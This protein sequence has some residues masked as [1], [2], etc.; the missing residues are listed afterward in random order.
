MRVAHFFCGEKM[1]RIEIE[2]LTPEEIETLQVDAALRLIG[3]NTVLLTRV[4]RQIGEAIVARGKAD[5]ELQQVKN[6][7]STLVELLRALKVICERA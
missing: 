3:E 5:M 1:E 2:T 6:D 4:N 7:K